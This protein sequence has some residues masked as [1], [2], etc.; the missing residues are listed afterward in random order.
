[1]FKLASNEK[2]GGYLSKKIASRYDSTRQFCVKYLECENEVIN[3][4]TIQ[5]L[6]N[7]MSQIKQGKKSIQVYD[8]PVFSKLLSISCEEILSAG[9]FFAKCSDRMTNYSISFS[10]EE[11]EWI[12]YINN[13]EELIL[14]PDEYGKTVIDY[15]IEFKNYNLLKFLIEKKYIWFDSRKDDDYVLT[16]GAGTS[17]QRKDPWRIADSL[18]YKLAAEDQLRMKIITMAIEN[19]DIQIL[20]ELRARELP[21]LYYKVHYMYSDLDFDSRYDEN[22]I[23]TLVESNNNILDYFTDE[24]PVRDRIKYT[25]GTERRHIFMFPFISELLDNLARKKHKFL[26]QALKKSI[27]HNKKIYTKLKQLIQLEIDRSMS[28]YDYIKDDPKYKS[29]LLE[30]IEIDIINGILQD[31]KFYENSKVIC[32]YSRESGDGMVTNII[33]I[34]E[35]IEEKGLRRYAEE[36]NDLYKK[37][38][39]I[40]EEFINR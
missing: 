16:F 39:N 11:E 34:K 12:R 2:I 14:N 31:F 17:I 40:N 29:D 3:E 20:D 36:L 15:A 38:I 5:K 35:T 19:G 27:T 23:N 9:Q 30:K 22:F 24:F 1:M 32:Y 28:R 33:K 8:L 13:E 18:Q 4:E 26:E 10:Q 6:S 7:R 25:N 37:I 21:E